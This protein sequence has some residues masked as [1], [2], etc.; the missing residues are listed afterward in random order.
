[1][2]DVVDLACTLPGT[3]A[4]CAVADIAQAGAGAAKDSVLSGIAQ[5]F[6]DGYAA[7]LKATLGLW[8]G[9]GSGDLGGAGTAIAA[10]RADTAWIVA[11]IAVAS[12]LAGAVRLAVSRNS[13]PAVDMTRGLVT[14]VVVTGAGVPA[15]TAL[16][17]A[18]DS[19][20]RWVL[21]R[22]GGEELGERLLVLTSALTGGDLALGAGA[23]VLLA[24]VGIVVSVVQVALM[25]VRV[26]VL[27]LLA[28]FLPVLA[29]GTG[30]RSGLQSFQRAV[31]WVLAFCLYKPLA[32]TVYAMAFWLIG[33]GTDVVAVV[34]GMTLL[35][36]SVI[37]L[38]AL[39]RLLTPAVAAMSSGGGGGGLAAAGM[40]VATGARSLPSRSPAAAAVPAPR[41]G[42][43]SG[44]APRDPSG[45]P[46]GA[47]DATGART[48]MGAAGATGAAG[49]PAGRAGAAAGAAVTVASGAQRSAARSVG[50]GS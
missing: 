13:A 20:S 38:P 37:A 14:L 24:T 23:V 43:A 5:T 6:A 40:V 42:G 17:S 30:T 9:A 44:G 26:G 15:I 32:A 46:T 2:A 10:L 49:T 33:T 29:A 16:W 18:G 41:P 8:L 48:S 22:A 12:L 34:S 31:A 35:A 4:A 11:V 19:Y 28:G 1:V 27:T 7:L 3:K 47:R 21:D 45:A 36:L 50:G 39:L 25:T